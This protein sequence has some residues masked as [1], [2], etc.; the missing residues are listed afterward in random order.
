MAAFGRESG[1]EWRER[2]G[3]GGRGAWG[4]ARECGAKWGGQGRAQS[5]Y[6]DLVLHFIYRA[7]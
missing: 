1:V 5:K 2:I 7:I 3:E 6:F 4:G